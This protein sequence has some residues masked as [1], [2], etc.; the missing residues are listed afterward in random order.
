M[1]TFT[2]PEPLTKGSPSQETCH[3][4]ECS[5]NSPHGPDIR[6]SQDARSR[7]E[8]GS[9]AQKLLGW[10]EGMINGKDASS[11]AQRHIVPVGL[12]GGPW[13]PDDSQS[14]RVI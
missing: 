1:S 9:H 7:S 3:L 12:F 2:A 5:P 10:E 14:W 11:V 4:E 8:S 13:I 6:P